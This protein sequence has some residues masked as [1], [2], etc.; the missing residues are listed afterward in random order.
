MAF[1][2]RILSRR[3]TPAF[4]GAAP[5]AYQGLHS[6]IGIVANSLAAMHWA[7]E[8]GVGC[9][10]DVRLLRDG[11]LA[12]FGDDDLEARTG[13]P[14]AIE[15]RSL[16]ELAPLRLRGSGEPIPSLAQALDAIAGRIP[17]LIHLISAVDG[18][19]AGIEALCS[20]MD[21]Y[22]G[23]FAILL[24]HED[25]ALWMRD[26]APEIVRGVALGYPNG[27]TAIAANWMPFS[28]QGLWRLRADFVVVSLG[29]LSALRAA[30]SNA[31]LPLLVWTVRSE[32]QWRWASAYAHNFIFES[33]PALILE[34]G[35]GRLRPVARKLSP[36]V[37][38][39]LIV[40]GG[41]G[42]SHGPRIAAHRPAA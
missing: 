19:R 16:E 6:H 18:R 30:L 9:E 15:E 5:F 1:L 17:L 20:A 34:A 26:N 4:L 22:D 2:S 35:G 27:Q 28:R 13:V 38:C 11:S 40:G 32:D 7:I 14:G 33:N 29:G 10:I 42:C 39:G 36:D 24:G 25:Q 31:C 23:D 12:L 37:A 3:E 41:R 21:G 8:Q